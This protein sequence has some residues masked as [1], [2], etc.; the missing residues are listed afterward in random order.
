MENSARSKNISVFRVTIALCLSLYFHNV[1]FY[2]LISLFLLSFS[3]KET[4]LYILFLAIALL[5]SRY[6]IDFMPFGIVELKSYNYYVV[7][8]L[9]YKT[10][11]YTD[12]TLLKGDIIRCSGYEK[13]SEISFLKK[14]ILFSGS[15]YSA[16]YSFIP[17]MFIEKQ[18]NRLDE[19]TSTVVSKILYNHYI[20]DESRGFIHVRKPI[21]PQKNIKPL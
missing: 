2:I 12:E 8:K 15:Q 18:L 19:A 1:C 17:R 20:D 6:I 10:A 21:L 11:V 14:N 16:E 9:F 4:L 3:Y 7:D 5:I 13:C